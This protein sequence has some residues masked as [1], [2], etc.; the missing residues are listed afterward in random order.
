MSRRVAG[1]LRAD[2]CWS[3]SLSALREWRL[4]LELVLMGARGLLPTVVGSSML[5]CRLC[6]ISSSERRL[7]SCLCQI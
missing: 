1:G 3:L 7:P 2:G 6:H 4:A 5:L